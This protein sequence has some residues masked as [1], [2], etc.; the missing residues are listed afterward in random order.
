MLVDVFGAVLGVESVGIHDNF[1]TVGG[2]SMLALAVR[3]EAEK[4]GLT[5]DIEALFAR[6]TIAE[7]A[8]SCQWAPQEPHG[9]TEPFA[10][11]AS[12]DRAAL[13]DAA[14]AFPATALQLGML[15]HSVR[16]TE[17]AMYK[18]VFRYRIAML[19]EERAFR[20]AFDRLVERH[21]ALRSSFD[22]STCSVPVQVVNPRVPNAMSVVTGADDVLV[23]DYIF[24]RHSHRYEFDRAPLDKSRVFVHEDVVDLCFCLPPRDSGRLECCEPDAGIV[25]GL[26][27][28]PRSRR[29]T[30]GRSASLDRDSGRSCSSGDRSSRRSCC[31]R[32]LDSCDIRIQRDVARAG[33]R[34]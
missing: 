29:F 18:D 34:Q 31:S 30:G 16:S 15:F 14:D 24:V 19:W 32:V 12:T 6:P 2:D 33:R 8:E 1:F 20:A 27:V 10:L 9:I 26:P 3:S 23:R 5:F 21:P 4:R 25:A 7:L 22:L 28:P 13:P 11:L 17:S